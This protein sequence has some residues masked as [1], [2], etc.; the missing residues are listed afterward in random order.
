MPS[1]KIFK[2]VV[3][4]LSEYEQRVLRTISILSRSRSRSYV[5]IEVATSDSADFAVVDSDDPRA[6]VYWNAFK[7]KNPMA[8]AVTVGSHPP[9]ESTDFHIDRP[10]MATQLLAVLDQM[11][12]SKESP[13]FAPSKAYDTDSIQPAGHTPLRQQPLAKRSVAGFNALV[14]DDSLPIRR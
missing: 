9:I 10:I 8:P 3:F 14:V 7:N 1:D 4:G 5:L 12:V 11:H 2:L 13:A 6:L